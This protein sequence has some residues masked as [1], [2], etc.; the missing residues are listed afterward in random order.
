MW[1]DNF[2]LAFYRIIMKTW[3]NPNYPDENCPKLFVYGRRAPKCCLK[4][5]AFFDMTI[6]SKY[7]TSVEIQQNLFLFFCDTFQNWSFTGI[8][9]F[10]W[11]Q[12][13]V[14]RHQISQLAWLETTLLMKIKVF[15]QVFSIAVTNFFDRSLLR[16]NF[17]NR[18]PSNFLCE[19][20][21]LAISAK[22][23]FRFSDFRFDKNAMEKQKV[24]LIF[25]ADFAQ[26]NSI[27]NE[28]FEVFF[29][30]VKILDGKFFSTLWELSS[31]YFSI[32]N[33]FSCVY[34]KMNFQIDPMKENMECSFQNPAKSS[35]WKFNLT[36][37]FIYSYFA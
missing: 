24:I 4:L 19:T 17:E 37:N 20:E 6:F 21:D 28:Y 25:L 2:F 1:S 13:I 32:S 12:K 23:Y 7:S 11:F 3:A 29:P 15:A 8:P 22:E 14:L 16:I 36:Y 10:C 5:D 33:C 27:N 26:V 31:L 34:C 30:I 9:S 35:R 18:A